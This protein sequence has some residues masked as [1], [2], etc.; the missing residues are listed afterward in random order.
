ML[1]AATLTANQRTEK[2]NRGSVSTSVPSPVSSCCASSTVV[3]GQEGSRRGR[4]GVRG[5]EGERRC[6]HS[7]S[8]SAPPPSHA[9]S[10]KQKRRSSSIH[11][12]ASDNDDEDE[13]DHEDDYEGEGT[14]V[15]TTTVGGS[16]GPGLK[17][18]VHVGGFTDASIAHLYDALSMIDPDKQR[19]WEQAKKRCSPGV[20][21]HEACPCYFMIG[22]QSNPWEAASRMCTYWN[23]R[24]DMFGEEKAFE[25]LT[26]GSDD[27]APTGLTDQD[28]KILETGCTQLLPSDRQGRKI[29]LVQTRNV[30]RCQRPPPCTV[31]HFAKS[32]YQW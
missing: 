29:A 28:V 4:G 2:A 7:H 23:D 31:V 6:T 9:A 32:L 30:Q 20:L 21:A 19:G 18:H 24:I 8:S 11:E 26:I 12:D 25:A 16:A 13:E 1:P 10:K 27:A 3:E 14:T 22:C 5:A 15:V 17:K